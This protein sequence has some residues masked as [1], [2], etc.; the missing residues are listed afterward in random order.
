MKEPNFFILGA[1]K[2]GTTALAQYLSD[3]PKVF[4]TDPKE[5]HH[6]NT[7]QNYGDFKDAERYRKLFQDAGPEHQCVGE[8]S[9]WYLYSKDAVANIEATIGAPRYIAM[10]RN[11]VEMAA[12]LHEQLV[13]S[14]NENITSFE[15]AWAAQ[16]RSV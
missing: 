8:A 11:P 7:D 16:E 4:M 10:L 14:G 3:H 12:S 15:K 2:C 6:F 9:V 5:P 1:P 13:Y